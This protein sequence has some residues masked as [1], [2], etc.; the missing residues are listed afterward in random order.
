M[1]RLFL[2]TTAA[3]LVAAFFFAAS[4]LRPQVTPAER[5]RRVAE[6]NGCYACHGPEG[7]KGIPNPGRVDRT[8]PSFGALMMY[9][10]DRDEVRAWIRDGATPARA[11]SKTWRAEREKGAVRM[12]AYGKRL[13]SRE[14]EDLV[15]F[16]LAVAGEPAPE[17][18]L[19]AAGLER[20]TAL[21]CFGCHGAG[22]RLARPNPGSFKG[23]VPPWDGPDFP[24]L[25]RDRAEFE[26][27]VEDGVSRRFAANPLA[28]HFLRR[29]PLRMP[30]YG[31]YL[32]QGDL[33]SMWA[34]VTWLRGLPT[35]TP[36]GP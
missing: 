18:S 36:M 8:V 23:Y 20:A 30:A 6:A 14:I 22:A 2:L 7:S 35:V 10:E 28:M 15:A 32:R 5:G 25:V 21:G 11:Q 26:E 34:Y 29:A 1:R 9:A 24:E 31:K 12:P 16:V 19:A 4:T 27:W 17:D 3:A 13:T 33:N